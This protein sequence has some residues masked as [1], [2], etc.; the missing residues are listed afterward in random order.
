[1]NFTVDML[2]EF[3]IYVDGKAMFCYEGRTRK[4]WNL[5]QYLLICRDRMVPQ[6]ELIE[7]SHL[8]GT[9]GR[10]D[11][12]LKNLIYRLRRILENSD[13]PKMEY[14]IC[15][16]GSYGWNPEIPVTL[17]IDIFEQEYH[18]ARAAENVS[19]EEKLMY[20]LSAIELYKGE[21]LPQSQKEDW[22]KKLSQKFQDMYCNSLKTVYEIFKE[23]KDLRFMEELCKRSLTISPMNEELCC[24]YLDL[25]L[26]QKQFKEALKI[27]SDFTK[28]LSKEYRFWKN[29]IRKLLKVLP[30]FKRTLILSKTI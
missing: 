7:I 17:D 27:Y 30:M 3:T 8:H 13:L 6:E 18:A 9:E 10:A 2:G 15:G 25:L 11:N 22:V 24:L 23:K 16:R 12:S 21:F 1:M 5:L 26:Y 4:L 29:S 14:I 28:N 20:Y 19:Q